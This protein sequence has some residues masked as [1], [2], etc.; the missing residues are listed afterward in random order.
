MISK[1]SSGLN[2]EFNEIMKNIEE[3]KRRLSY[4]INTKNEKFYTEWNKNL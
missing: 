2:L 1:I 3:S 4:G